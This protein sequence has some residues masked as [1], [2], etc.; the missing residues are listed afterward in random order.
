V[1]GIDEEDRALAPLRLFQPGQ[2]FLAQVGRLLAVVGL[3][4]DRADLPPAQPDFF[5]KKARTWD[6]PRRMPVSRWMASWASRALR[7]GCSMK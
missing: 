6:R 5:F 4:R 3:R 7:G 2:E 1:R